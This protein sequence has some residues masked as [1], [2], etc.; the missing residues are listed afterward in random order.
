MPLLLTTQ[1]PEETIRLG[2]A[3]ARLC[4]AGDLVALEGELGAGKTQFVRGM[5]RG[6]GLCERS[7]SSPTF[8]TV[9][10][11]WPEDDKDLV[12]VHL[13]AWRFEGRPGELEGIGWGRA[14]EGLRRG[15]VAA[16]EWPSKLGAALG[17]D[18]LS[19][20][21]SHAGAT[22][23]EEGARRIYISGSGTWAAKMRSVVE[24]LGK[25]GFTATEAV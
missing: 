9:Q 3:L 23:T 11:Y 4:G 13:D 12:L 20:R 19:V 10:E 5:A 6:L 24:A 21:I 7:V 2:A 8:V 18:Y 1:T 17:T 15:A 22:Q 16:V 14:D 25:A